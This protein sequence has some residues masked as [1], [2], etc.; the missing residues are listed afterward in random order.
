MDMREMTNFGES[1]LGTG[2]PGG[3]PTGG[4]LNALRS[5]AEHFS[6]AADAAINQALSTDSEAWIQ[7]NRQ[8]G[9]E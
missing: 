9:G 5:S 3:N 8:E 7:A 6:S 2:V 1:R 4:N